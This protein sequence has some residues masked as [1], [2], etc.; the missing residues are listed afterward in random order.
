[1]GAWH[2]LWMPFRSRKWM[3]VDYETLAIQGQR[4]RGGPIFA[5][6]FESSCFKCQLTRL[7][8]IRVHRNTN[9]I[10]SVKQHIPTTSLRSVLP[11]IMGREQPTHSAIV[12]LVPKSLRS[13]DGKDTS[14]CQKFVREN[15]VLNYSQYSLAEKFN[16]ILLKLRIPKRSSRE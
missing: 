3:K 9:G 15:I 12:S 2:S 6:I 8:N 10:F 14:E 4:N 7:Y 5:Y 11:G 16:R 1:M 13:L